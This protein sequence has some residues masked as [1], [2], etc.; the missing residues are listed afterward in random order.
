MN[1]ILA[2]RIDFAEDALKDLLRLD[3][4]IARRIAVFLTQRVAPLD[5]PRCIGEALRGTKLGAY[6][7]DRVGDWR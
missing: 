3:P 6:W 7:K 1:A 2:W 4:P 5:D